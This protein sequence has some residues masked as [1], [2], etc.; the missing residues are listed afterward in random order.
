MV[1]Q[2]RDI[3]PSFSGEAENNWPPVEEKAGNWAIVVT[4]LPGCT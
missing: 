2:P 3:R 1:P 4:V